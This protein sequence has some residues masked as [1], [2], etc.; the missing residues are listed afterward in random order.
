M[1]VCIVGEATLVIELFVFRFHDVMNGFY[2]SLC[3]SYTV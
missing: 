3:I 2:E 1:I